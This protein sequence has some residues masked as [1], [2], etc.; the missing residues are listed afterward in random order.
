MPHPD[1]LVGV[2]QQVALNSNTATRHIL[3]SALSLSESL[4]KGL[5]LRLKDIFLYSDLKNSY[6]NAIG[7]INVET[8]KALKKYHLHDLGISIELKPDLEEKQHLENNIMKAL[9]RDQITFDDAID[10]RNIGNIK[11]SNELLKTRRIRREKI[12]QQNEV[13]KIQEQGKSQAQAAQAASQSKM[14]ELEAESKFKNML[15]NTKSKNKMQ[16][17]ET[18]A[19]LKSGLMREEFEYNMAI[20]GQE[21]E[22]SYNKD[23][24]K[25]DRKDQ[26]QD[27][28]NSQASAIAEQKAKGNPALN[29]ESQEDNISGSVDMSRLEPS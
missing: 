10:I 4:G 20:K 11:L 8:L 21:G 25:E 28:A 26:R 9:D 12:K 24:Y 15:E 18:E 2:Q 7:K 17:L 23:K 5:A 3:D 29:F 14:Q 1:T 6:I 16:E 13:E 19:R 27:R 22:I